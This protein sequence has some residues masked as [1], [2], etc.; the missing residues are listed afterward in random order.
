MNGKEQECVEGSGKLV[1]RFV[2][3]FRLHRLKTIDLYIKIIMA[4]CCFFRLAHDHPLVRNKC[5]I[6]SS[7][8]IK[9]YCDKNISKLVNE[10]TNYFEWKAGLPAPSLQ[11]LK[12]SIGFFP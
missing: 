1:A 5:N 2:M 3:K 6:S 10:M 8:N 11:E 7:S 4:C 12:H 9:I